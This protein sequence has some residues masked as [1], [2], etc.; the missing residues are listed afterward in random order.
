MKLLKVH[1][2]NYRCLK[3]VTLTFE[4]DLTPQVFPIGGENGGGKSTLLQL[5]F[6][7]LHCPGEFSPKKIFF[8]N[9][10]KKMKRPYE[11]WELTKYDIATI[12]LLYK[13]EKID[14]N[15]FLIPLTD[16]AD[17]SM[18]YPFGP[19][20]EIIN[21][22]LMIND[23]IKKLNQDIELRKEEF[24]EETYSYTEKIEDDKK[25][26]QYIQEL[27]KLRNYS[28][29]MRNRLYEKEK[30]CYNELHLLNTSSLD[31]SYEIE[32]TY[33]VICCQS[34]HPD[35]N[36]TKE[37]LDFAGKNVF[38]AGQP[39]QPYIFLNDNDIQ[40]LFN[41][42]GKYFEI[43]K[44]AR[45]ELPNFYT[46]DQFA[47]LAILEGFKKARDKDFE[48]VIET[49]TYGTSYQSLL[50][51][52]KSIIGGQKVIYP[53]KD[54]DSISVRYQTEDNKFIELGPGDLSHGELKRASLYA[55]I[56]YREINDAIVLIDEI[57]NGLHPDWQYQIVKDLASWGNNQYL[58]ATHSF[59]LCEA[60][61]P[62]HVK[63]IEP[64][65][66]N[67]VPEK[68]DHVPAA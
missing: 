18:S 62:R 7:L 12:Q 15:Y 60:L 28:K 16:N 57:E 39:T 38:I 11:T 47:L 14:L 20:M 59:Y 50:N 54:L 40:E 21:K 63:E 5:I 66:K 58:L 22:L 23:K 52:L 19:F 17:K 55:W 29:D 2:P 51:E 3:N 41:I 68:K 4:P 45:K 6:V 35:Y 27:Q 34:S 43:L 44:N 13:N 64:R 56:K 53:T 26:E 49:G 8:N 36:F 33:F 24:A 9:T 25:F 1:V 65:M 31:L 32:K 37:V 61:T 42:E 67:P 46:Y 10:I 30:E 48:K